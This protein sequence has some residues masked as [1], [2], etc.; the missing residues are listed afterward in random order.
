ML[1]TVDDRA[2]EQRLHDVGKREEAMYEKE[3]ELKATAA[4]IGAREDDLVVRA[5]VLDRREA[6]IAKREKRHAE[7]V[8]A[9]MSG[10][11]PPGASLP[12]LH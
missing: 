2:Y 12:D 5:A 4:A 7:H 9:V 11:K 8:K 3:R 1:I 10:R 6:L